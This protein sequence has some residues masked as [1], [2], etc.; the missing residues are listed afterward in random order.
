MGK[1][2]SPNYQTPS[3]REKKKDQTRKSILIEAEKIL[4]H[5]KDFKEMLCAIGVQYAVMFDEPEDML[6]QQVS[7]L[8]MAREPLGT[9][10]PGEEILGDLYS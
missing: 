4:S 10:E 1:K 9:Y 5:C 3:L 7:L 2:S 6:W 8:H